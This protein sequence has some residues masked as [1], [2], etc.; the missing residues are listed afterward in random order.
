[1]EDETGSIQRL[2]PGIRR[3]ASFNHHLGA[4]PSGG[5]SDRAYQDTNCAWCLEDHLHHPGHHGALLLALPPS[6]LSAPAVA[7]S[8]HS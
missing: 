3:F 7:N 4:L 8:G 5:T 1:M 2:Q 6:V